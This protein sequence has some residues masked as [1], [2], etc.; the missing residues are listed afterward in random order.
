ME[1]NNIS[2][3]VKKV[4]KK[5]DSSTVHFNRDFMRKVSRLVERANK[6]SFGRKVKPRAI[7][8]NLFHLAD[9]KL[10]ERVVKKAQEDSLSHNDKRE[11][12]L[13]ER[14]TKFNGSR[15]KMELKMMEIFDQ[16]LL[17]NQT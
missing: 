12:F 3:P 13:K 10:L 17:Q 8:E 7:L 15:E 6:K 2:R 1:Q 5:S 9:E 11:A 14:L 16:Y 4:S